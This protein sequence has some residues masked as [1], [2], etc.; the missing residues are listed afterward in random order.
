[1]IL[2]ILRILN[3][4]YSTA[5]HN[6]SFTRALLKSLKESGGDVLEIH[7][8]LID[9]RKRADYKLEVDPIHY[10]YCGR[11]YAPICGMP[12]TVEFRFKTSGTEPKCDFPES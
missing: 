2:R 12:E 6:A 7:G 9:S 4:E 8:S 10:E 3:T 5:L 11:R 1:M